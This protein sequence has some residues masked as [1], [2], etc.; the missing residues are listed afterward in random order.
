[1][2]TILC[3]IY[4]NAKVYPTRNSNFPVESLLKKK[5]KIDLI[6]Y[7]RNFLPVELNHRVDH[8]VKQDL[9]VIYKN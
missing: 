9:N 5:I 4:E 3:Y 1:M 2:Q 6:T 7:S 8:R